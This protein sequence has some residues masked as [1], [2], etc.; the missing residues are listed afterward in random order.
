MTGYLGLVGKTLISLAMRYFDRIQPRGALADLRYFF[1][2]RRPHQWGFAALSVTVTLV[3]IWAFWHDSKFEPVYHRDI[4]Y[5]QQWRADRSIAD[6]IA[7][8]KIDGPKEAARKA[9][10]AR[11]LEENRRYFQKMKDKTDGWL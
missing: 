4:I 1:G 2:Q 7:Q 10:E 5:V 11:R 8:Q 9:E 3:T 6:V